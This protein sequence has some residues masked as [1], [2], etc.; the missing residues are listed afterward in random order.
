[1]AVVEVPD[2]VSIFPSPQS[3]LVVATDPPGVAEEADRLSVT[4]VPVSAAVGPVICSESAV[5]TIIV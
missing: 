2:N 4:V 3:T 1:M 5:A